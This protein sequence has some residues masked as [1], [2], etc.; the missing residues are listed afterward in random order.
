M[1]AQRL[2]VRFFVTDALL[3]RKQA[4]HFGDSETFLMSV[5]PM[6]RFA[7][8]RVKARGDSPKL[9]RCDNESEVCRKRCAYPKQCDEEINSC[10]RG[11]VLADVVRSSDCLLP[12]TSRAAMRTST[13]LPLRAALWDRPGSSKSRS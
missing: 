2:L 8:C 13:A 10:L 4:G 5:L 12:T 1:F 6:S 11:S 9:V 7:V 3:G